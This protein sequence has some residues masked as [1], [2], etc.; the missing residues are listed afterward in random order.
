M[1][2]EPTSP[3]ADD[4]KQRFAPRAK[5]QD[6]ENKNADGSSILESPCT[7]LTTLHHTSPQWSL[8]NEG[9][10]HDHSCRAYRTREKCRFNKKPY[11]TATFALDRLGHRRIS[12]LPAHP[13]SRQRS[14]TCFSK[15]PLPNPSSFSWASTTTTCANWPRVQAKLPMVRSPQ[16]LFSSSHSST[17]WTKS[18]LS[19]SSRS[20]SSRVVVQRHL[21]DS[22]PLGSINILTENH[23]KWLIWSILPREPNHRRPAHHHANC[24]QSTPPS[25]RDS[26]M[27]HDEPSTWL[28]TSLTGHWGINI[29]T[30]V[31]PHH[32]GAFSRRLS[33][34]YCFNT[35]HIYPNSGILPKAIRVTKKPTWL[36][37]IGRS[38]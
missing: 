21:G 23:W 9:C 36:T 30:L 28:Y 16:K 31:P 27:A 2:F 5:R 14:R 12:R 20:V 17:V 35:T 8:Q 24:H 15:K 22:N 34:N 10:Y 26:L 13:S 1:G 19:R 29:I 6:L 18:T 32:A 3:S 25:R 37:R 4:R 7:V 38:T 33:I 11:P